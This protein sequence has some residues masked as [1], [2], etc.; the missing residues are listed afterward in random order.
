LTDLNERGLIC[1]KQGLERQFGVTVAAKA[2]D[3]TETASFDDL[4]EFIDENGIRFDMLLNIAGL[5]HEGAF[6]S[7]SSDQLASIVALNDVATVRI[8]HSILKRRRTGK[9]FTIVFMSSLASMFPMPVKAT[10]AASKRFILD[11]SFALRHELK[12]Q[13]VNVMALCPGGMVTTEEAVKA[14]EAQGFWGDITTS[15]LEIVARK[16][17]RRATAGKSIY[18]PGIFNRCLA[19]LGRLVP[20]SIVA[21]VV[22]RRWSATGKN[23]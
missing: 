18:I 13:R 14:I 3:L 12:E 15:P 1:L 10:Y 17:L 7:R 23:T 22:F 20:R 19:F 4:L 5:D 6:I 16:M 8:T 21:A 2:C 9:P 11:L